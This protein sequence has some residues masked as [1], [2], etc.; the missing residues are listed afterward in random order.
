MF[1]SDTH[2]AAYMLIYIAYQLET[3]RLN[4]T[5][6]SVPTFETKVR[7]LF[8][9]K[10]E[11]AL[12]ERLTEIFVAALLVPAVSLVAFEPYV[13]D[14]RP[15]DGIFRPTDGQ[16]PPSTDYAILLPDGYVAIEVTVLYIGQLEKWQQSIISIPYYSSQEDSYFQWHLPGGRALAASQF[17]RQAW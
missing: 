9:E 4:Q 5:S 13:P 17:R 16:P 6:K 14:R 2:L 1:E 7:S 8:T 11:K 12:D 10:N 15:T 3:L